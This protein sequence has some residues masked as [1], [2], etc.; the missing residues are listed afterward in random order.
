[1]SKVCDC[2]KVC[3]CTYTCICFVPCRNPD[4]EV[5][6]YLGIVISPEE[7]QRLEPEPELELEPEPELEQDK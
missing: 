2:P 5:S 1:M 3:G 4:H 6:Y 7:L